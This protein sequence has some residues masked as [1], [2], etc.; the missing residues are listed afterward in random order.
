MSLPGDGAVDPGTTL[1]KP[2]AWTVHLL[3]VVIVVVSSNRGGK[4]LRSRD[5]A[6]LLLSSACHKDQAGDFY[7]PVGVLPW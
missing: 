4:R 6:S 5:R 7:F 1:W 3:V 2:R